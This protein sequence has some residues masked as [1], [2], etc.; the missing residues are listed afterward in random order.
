MPCLVLNTAKLG[1][2]PCC[3]T[4]KK[5]GCFT[6]KISYFLSSH[7]RLSAEG[8]A[9]SLKASFVS[10]GYYFNASISYLNKNNTYL[11]ENNRFFLF[12]LL[13]LRLQNQN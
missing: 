8:T 7:V 4:R 3:K 10:T 11:N 6:G 2:Y 13:Y 1:D 9:N 5:T 12:L